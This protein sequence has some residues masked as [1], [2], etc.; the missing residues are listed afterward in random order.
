MAPSVFSKLSSFNGS[1]FF[2]LDE[3]HLFGQGIGRLILKLIVEVSK[4]PKK[5]HSYYHKFENGT[6]N[7]DN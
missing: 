4:H 2:A 1:S 7:V 5:N 3:L 6:F